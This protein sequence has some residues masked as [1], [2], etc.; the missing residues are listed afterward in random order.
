MAGAK[1]IEDIFSSEVDEK[2]VSA[3]VGSLVTKLA[4]QN[5]KA[6]SGPSQDATVT[7]NHVNDNS[8]VHAQTGPGG[9]TTLK[10]AEPGISIH[11][12]AT[13]QTMQDSHLGTTG[14]P[15]TPGL[16]HENAPGNIHANDNATQGNGQNNHGIGSTSIADIVKRDSQPPAISNMMTK[17]PTAT[18]VSVSQQSPAI[19]A[20]IT[21]AGLQKPNEPP[22][23]RPVSGN[24]MGQIRT[25]VGNDQQ[26]V[27]VVSVPSM[28]SGSA[29]QN[30]NSSKNEHG[31]TA[32]MNSISNQNVSSVSAGSAKE[33]LLV[34]QQTLPSND[35]SGAMKPR[36]VVQPSIAATIQQAT[37][38]VATISGVPSGNMTLGNANQK[39]VTIN[40]ANP[41]TQT[42][43]R[44]GQY[45]VNTVPGSKAVSPQI[46]TQ[47]VRMP[48]G[49]HVIAPRA[50][51]GGQVQIRL[52]PGTTLPPGVVLINKGGTVQAVMGNP[53][54]IQAHVA[55]APG[56]TTYRHV[57]PGIV[58]ST[59]Q[60]GR[61]LTSVGGSNASVVSSPQVTTTRSGSPVV[62]A[63]GTP[64][65]AM[66]GA[67]AANASSQQTS[68]LPKATG[69]GQ[70]S[71][72]SN[73]GG[74][75]S[76]SAMDNVKKC[77]N[78]LTTL[79]KLASNANQ[80]PE[81]VQNVKMLV[82]SLIDAKIEPEEFTLKLQKELNS[83][84]QPYLVPFLKRSLPLLRQTLQR[85]SSG[86]NITTLMGPLPAAASGSADGKPV[87]PAITKITPAA[88]A[89]SIAAEA[90][91][92]KQSQQASQKHSSSKNSKASSPGRSPSP[93]TKPGVSKSSKSSSQSS[94]KSSRS[95]GSKSSSS[96]SS[97]G[98]ATPRKDKSK[99]TSASF[100]RDDDDIND[101]ASMA[102]V[103][104]SEESARILATNEAF[105]GTQLRSCEDEKFLHKT[106][107]Q[108]C[109]SKIC[110]KHGISDATPAVLDVV[111]LAVQER[112]KQVVEK[113]S[114]ISQ[115]RLEIYRSDTRYEPMNDVRSQLKFFEQLDALERKRRDEQER[116]IL[117][118]A[119][120]S[121]SKQED[122]EQLRLKQKAK[123]MQQ[124]ELEQLRQ[125][126]ANLTALAAIGPRKKR[127]LDSETSS[128][129]PGGASGSSSSSLLSTLNSTSSNTTPFLRTQF[130]RTKRVNMKDLL[131]L[132]EQEPETKRSQLLYK[133]YLK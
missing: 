6:A 115:H 78:F 76:S 129:S 37:S 23:S 52:P 88:A 104:L 39:V 75:L 110:S 119:A 67:T 77:R 131:Y 80:P 123:E 106:P 83:S 89:A 107:L 94:S 124:M 55:G 108:H 62:I 118:R 133:M 102:G 99:D 3:L 61:I 30:T 4:P 92:G 43:G 113:L 18:T 42:G 68:S 74:Q 36:I 14:A 97:G 26:I 122:P 28:P 105:V 32:N 8:S 56:M 73:S 31:A 25:S 120:K 116:E 13:R 103:N 49:H 50:Q 27:K 114:V 64:T 53:A 2:E 9:L 10:Q 130:R 34:R 19:V 112:L 33:Q 48:T 69:K 82:Q 93:Q 127:K 17:P 71:S 46:I 65:T 16:N 38:G 54:A 11:A 85:G 90:K 40:V 35:Q 24:A 20:Q 60:P 22:I 1:S 126:E 81:T 86:S 84:P 91:G 59:A 58:T 51:L 96:K 128:S 72:S 29:V 100:S 66:R 121:R 132:M 95:S 117:L 98:K 70:G 47:T 63:S 41:A 101:V 45:V 79:I 7:R 125:Q 57:Q 109:M 15:T 87:K 44:P 21:G 111:S 12:N 5:P